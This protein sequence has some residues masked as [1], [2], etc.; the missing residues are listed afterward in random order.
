M[1]NLNTDLIETIISTEAFDRLKK[2]NEQMIFITSIWTDCTHSHNV[3]ILK[4][5][6][7]P[8]INETMISSDEWLET[9]SKEVLENNSNFVAK[10]R[11]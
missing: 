2:D 5:G 6:R 7:L 9:S 1:R 10:M 3:V 8:Y 4:K 11:G